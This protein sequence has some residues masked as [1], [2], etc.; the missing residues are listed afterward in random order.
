MVR[1]LEMFFINNASHSRQSADISSLLRNLSRVC[2][3]FDRKF[4]RNQR[5]RWEYSRV[6][7]AVQNTTSAASDTQQASR[8]PADTASQLKT[9]VGRFKLSGSSLAL[10]S[11]PRTEN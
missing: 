8:A 5:N 1:L 4:K 11:T 2:R 7:Q 9:L 3:R 10:G 6:A